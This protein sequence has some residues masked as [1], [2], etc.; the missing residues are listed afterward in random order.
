MKVIKFGTV[1]RDE[2]GYII[3]RDFVI[4]DC[5]K[6]EAKDDDMIAACVARHVLSVIGQDESPFTSLNAERVV[7]AAIRKAREA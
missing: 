3:F 4:S 5:T 6:A 7:N 1:T 2:N